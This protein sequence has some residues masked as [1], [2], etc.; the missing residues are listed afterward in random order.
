M[1]KIFPPDEYARVCS[2]LVAI[3]SSKI[4]AHHF[5]ELL[6]VLG[7]CHENGLKTKLH[8]EREKLPIPNVYDAAFYENSSPARRKIDEIRGTA[9]GRKVERLFSVLSDFRSL[10]SAED[11]LSEVV[12]MGFDNAIEQMAE[13]RPVTKASLQLAKSVTK[14]V[15][16]GA[17]ATGTAAI[18]EA[19]NVMS[20]GIA[21][22]TFFPQAFYKANSAL[23]LYDLLPIHG[24]DPN[25]CTCQRRSGIGEPPCTLIAKHLIEKAE[26]G[27]GSFAIGFFAGKTPVVG[28]VVKEALNTAMT[29]AERYAN[30]QHADQEKAFLE[31]KRQLAVHLWNAAQCYGSYDR[32]EAEKIV[33]GRVGKPG[34]TV[35]SRGCPKAIA[36][37][38]KLFGE[39]SKNSNY[40]RTLSA[41]SAVSDGVSVIEMK[42]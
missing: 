32:K 33:I 12:E 18:A 37:I 22:V 28:P 8:F 34:I 19:A 6:S 29:I 41:I 14:T 39:L 35:S 42:L 11:K 10:V 4:D 24:S 40:L 16:A 13:D 2:S 20:L 25:A 7:K 36:V 1:N 26:K 3:R 17:A 9:T 27:M 21:L 5:S 30:D 31:N 38:A 15:A 23:S